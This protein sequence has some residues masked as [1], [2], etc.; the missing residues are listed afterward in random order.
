MGNSRTEQQHNYKVVRKH[1]DTLEGI[2][3]TKQKSN[4]Y[5]KEQEGKPILTGE[6]NF[7]SKIDSRKGSSRKER[8]TYKT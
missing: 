1:G 4:R 8:K 6:F 5:K 7:S 3:S 2:V